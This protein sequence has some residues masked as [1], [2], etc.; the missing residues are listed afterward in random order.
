MFLAERLNNQQEMQFERGTED[1]KTAHEMMLDF[2]VPLLILTAPYTLRLTPVGREMARH[3][4]RAALDGCTV[5][6]NAEFT[7]IAG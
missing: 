5:V 4:C 7:E 6:I 2:A 3:Y 1:A